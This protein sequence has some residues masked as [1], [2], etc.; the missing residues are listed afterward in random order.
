MTQS[1]KNYGS[2]PDFAGVWQ[3]YEKLSRGDQSQLGKRI[4][5]PDDLFMV[6]AFYKLFPGITPNERYRQVAFILPWCRHRDGAKHLGS[7]LAVENINEKR[8]FQVVR[9]EFPND[10]IY[11][12]RL[13]Q[14]TE[15]TVNW[16]NFGK[17]L[18]FWND[19][20]I[21]KRQLIEQYF[22]TRYST[23]KGE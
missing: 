3:R 11:L 15:F 14:R 5:S 12:R 1:A 19:N 7:L 10:L 13:I 20:D 6:P 22:V 8:I 4:G 23:K 17:E 2:L 18:F 16:K 21:A 9:S